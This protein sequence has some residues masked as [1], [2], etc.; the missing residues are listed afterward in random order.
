M[1][2]PR[3]FDTAFAYWKAEID[4]ACK[5]EEGFRKEGRE[6][7]EIYEGAKAEDVPFNIIYS[8][9][10]TLSPALYNSTPRPVVRRRFKDSDPVGKAGSEI[11]QRILQFYMDCGNPD[12]TDFDAL[13]KSAVLEALLPG[14][15]VTKFRYDATMET[16]TPEKLAPVEGAQPEAPPE[17]YEKV[18]YECVVGEEVPWDRFLT[19]YAKKWRN[20]PWIAFEYF[21]TKEEAEEEFGN[22]A[23]GWDYVDNTKEAGDE[24]DRARSDEDSGPQKTVHVYQIWH[25]AKKQVLYFAPSVKEGYL[26]PPIDDPLKLQGF[27]PIPR[28]LGFLDKPSSII[29][30]CLYNLYRNQAEELN[31]IT[32][33]INKL[34]R[35]LKVA[36]AYDANVQEIEKVLEAGDGELVG[37]Q[38]VAA[39]SQKGGS[40]ESA[41]WLIPL[42]KII[43]VL[44]QLYIQRQQCK[45]VI[46]EI[47]GVSDILRGSTVASETATAQEIKNQ[48]GTLRL[49]RWQKEVQRYSKDCLRIMAEI[50]VSKLG[51]DTISA[52]TGVKLPTA[53]EQAMAQ[54]ALQQVQVAIM[55]A[56]QSAGITPGQ[57]PQPDPMQVQQAQQAQQ[58]LSQPSW[59]D[60]LSMLQGDVTRNYHI[61]IETNSTVDA[62][63]TEDKQEISDILNA[64]AQFI[65]GI[66]PLVESGVMPFEGAQAML[67]MIVRRFRMGEDIEDSLMKMKPPQKEDDGKAKAQEIKNQGEQQKQ[68][69]EIDKMGREADL[70]KQALQLKVLEMQQEMQFK[71]EEHNLKMR[72]L[73]MKAEA[74]GQAHL[75]KMEQLKLQK[76]MPSGGKSNGNSAR[77]IPA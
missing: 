67:M 40:L 41:I 49:K 48:W 47:T 14:R 16:V 45:Q 4:A 61:D 44:Q 37:A 52:M 75:Q 68:K 70:E 50:A 28:P 32:I 31:R 30:S 1:A 51:K 58:I 11:T 19:G 65:S 54:A 36:G 38:N 53:E 2:E 66:A 34:I 21:Y 8:N 73:Q 39:L 63:A 10:E 13:M 20:V 55:G 42:E 17:P 9:T 27:Y 22:T 64:M 29:P 23:A 18:S 12:E 72:E 62:E 57:P 15:G 60:V 56:Q 76:T 6:V 74:A 69:F 3:N 7:V 25:K 77:N 5:R 35:M 24:G 33:R 26:K 59:E 71:R 46:Y 43:Q